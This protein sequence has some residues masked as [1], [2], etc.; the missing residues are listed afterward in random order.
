[1]EP[2]G[3][4]PSLFTQAG[5]AAPAHRRIPLNAVIVAGFPPWISLCYITFVIAGGF[6]WGT[7]LGG[8]YF[9]RAVSVRLSAGRRF[10]RLLKEEI[11]VKCR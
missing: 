1:M 5:M 9:R 10:F 7:A 11:E 4:L 8:F 6:F 3:Q 2:S